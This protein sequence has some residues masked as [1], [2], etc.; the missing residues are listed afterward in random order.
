MTT[1]TIEPRCDRHDMVAAWCAPCKGTD[2]PEIVPDV[3][4]P[5]SGTHYTAP[6]GRVSPRWFLDETERCTTCGRRPDFAAL[7]PCC[8]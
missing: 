1:T 8:S 5:G 6:V 7:E 4:E 2:D 3:I